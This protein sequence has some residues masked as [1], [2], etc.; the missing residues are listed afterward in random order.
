[1]GHRI[2]AMRYAKAAFEI[3]AKDD[4]LDEWQTDLNKMSQ[5]VGDSVVYSF[6]VNPKIDFNRKVKLLN[7]QYSTIN[8]KV[9]NL[10]FLLISKRRLEI[11]NDVAQEFKRLLNY[12]RGIQEAEVSTA[13]E[14]NKKELEILGKELAHILGK[15]LIIKPKVVPEIISGMVIRIGD[16]LI[17]G[18]TVNNL[19]VLKKEIIE[20]RV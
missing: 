1:M 20:T 13:I 16:R 17:D 12:K 10:I 18:S 19:N 9:L 7:T 3:A 4:E 15:R 11:I 6:L 5:F 8:R 14:L 2:V